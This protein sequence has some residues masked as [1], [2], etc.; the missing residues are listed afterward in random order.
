MTIVVYSALMK[1]YAHSGLYDKACDLYDQIQADNLE[2]DAMMYGCLMK[3]SAECGRTDLSR[4]LS[5][6]SPTLDIQNYMSLI[7]AAGRD[8]DAD[9]AFSILNRLKESG[10]NLDVAAYN[11]VLDVCVSVRDMKRARALVDQMKAAG[12]HD[13]ITF[14]TLLKGHCNVGDWQG[15]KSL[16]DEMKI[17]GLKPNDVS[18]NCLINATVSSGKFNEAWEIISLMQKNGVSADHYTISIMMKALKKVKNPRQVASVLELLDSS[19]IDVCSD[20]VLLNTVAETCIWHKNY[21]RLNGLLKAFA[22]SGLRPSVPTYGSLIKAASSLKQVDKCWQFWRQITEDRAME[23]SE[24]VL[25][26]M[27][28]ALVTNDCLE[29]AESLLN[30]WKTRIKPNTVMYSTIIKGLATSRQSARAMDIWREMRAMKIPMNTV[31]YNALIDAQARVGAM[32]EVSTLVSAMEPDGCPPDV[33]TFSTIVKGY[34]VKGELT[35]AL[36]VFKSIERN[37]MVADAI[38]YNTILDGC[39]RHNNMELADKLVAN[40]EVYTVNPSNFTLG[41]LVKM[42]GRRGQLEKAFEVAQTLPKRYGFTPNAQV[43][44]CLMHAC[45]N[46]RSI[47]R[48]FQVFEEL[49]SSREGADVKA[50]GALLSGCI[51]H[52]HLEEAVG[53][54]EDAYGLQD[55]KTR[56]PRGEF[57]EQERMDALFHSLAQNGLMEKFGA[58]LV[59]KLRANKVP[60]SNALVTAALS[61]NNPGY[62]KSQPQGNNQGQRPWA[63]NGQRPWASSGRQHR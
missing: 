13:I 7:R 25:G 20:E 21:E 37:G 40:M 58:G 55:P 29:Q 45:V 6:K 15:A 43:R 62:R 24:I 59:E 54:V 2:P 53:L 16:L 63:S 44:T 39:I 30:Q 31:C 23:P 46:N 48:A 17:C 19:K 38:I 11:C 3:F 8:R 36:E 18:Y 57:L 4:H 50:Y 61:G 9:R 47:R 35:K 22:L 26:C 14:N 1:V 41:I 10:V 42:Y 32:D 27:L 33:I 28:D 52:G 5:E 12:S 60:V 34:C 51:R 49:K 56:L